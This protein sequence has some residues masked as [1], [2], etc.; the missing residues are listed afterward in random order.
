MSIFGFTLGWW[1]AFGLIGNTI[2]GTRF[3]VQWI[4]SEKAR[5]SVVPTAFWWLSI[6][7]S[8]ILLLYF[9][10]MR[11]IVGVLAYLPNVIP[12]SRNLVLI[13]RHKNQARELK[14]A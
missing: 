9:I 13:Y 4:A 2:F 6:A 11:S 10:H 12:Y 3:F 1:E 14:G 7:G 5:Q 8:I